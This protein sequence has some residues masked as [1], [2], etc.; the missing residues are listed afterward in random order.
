[1]VSNSEL[2]YEVMNSSKL[3]RV[4]YA[5]NC[6][7][8]SDS[9]FLYECRGCNNC[10]GCTN[11]RNKSYYIFN[12]PYSKE[13]YLKKLREF[14]LESASGVKNARERFLTLKRDALRKYA[15][16]V[17]SQNATGDNLTNV[18]NCKDS[19]DFA[20]DVRDCRFCV[21]GGVKTYDSYDGYGIGA[22][23]ELTYESVDTGADGNRFYFDIFVWTGS[24]VQYS[25]ACHGCQNCFGCIGLRKKEYCILNKQYSKEE[26]KE[27]VPRII[28]QMSKIPYVDRKG[29]SY[30][31]GE[32][33]PSEFSPFSYNE[34]IAQEY[35][36]L[37]K[38][39]AEEK[40]YRWKDRET[41]S[42][43][44]SLRSEDILDRLDEVNDGILQ[45]IIGC[46][47]KGACAH[48]C[49]TAFRIIPEELAFYRRMHLPLPRLCPNCRHYERLT[50]RNPIKLWHRQCQCAGAGSENGA[51]ANTATHQHGTGRCTNEF[52]TSYAPERPEVVYCDQCYQ[53]EVV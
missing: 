25:Y 52:E 2:C 20:N 33:F 21:K 32:F 31:Y 19:F 16:I 6:E 27:L 46:A 40:G 22:N 15:N 51:Y 5:E 3:Y 47:H 38:E 23:T 24:D 43:T 34:T 42:Y 17:N 10:V 44:V 7:G 30:S 36:P 39:K 35:F 4:A 12:E 41:K 29:A 8:C 11:L 9:Y 45:E 1:M 18:S 53:S 28:E 26:Y 49:A 37:T 13:E 48:Q 14:D 50:E